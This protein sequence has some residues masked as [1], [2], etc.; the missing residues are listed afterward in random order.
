MC[1]LCGILGADHWADHAGA[2]AS[3][4]RT[5]LR[6]ARLLNDVLSWYRLPVDDWHGAV[7]AV[8][9]PTGRTELAETLP[10]LWRKAEAIANRALD[11]LDPLLLDHLAGIV[12]ER[13]A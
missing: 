8:R 4:R 6:R 9:G 10:E 12:R 5:R 11:P 2:T 7:T 1:G 3:L 13:G